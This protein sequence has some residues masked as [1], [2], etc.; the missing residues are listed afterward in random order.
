[1]LI[2]IPPNTDRTVTVLSWIFFNLIIASSF[3]DNWL[4]VASKNST[5]LYAD[6]LYVNIEF[7]EFPNVL[8]LI[9]KS[10]EYSINIKF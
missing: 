2:A 3:V 10:L 9:C 6:S 8:R 4:E 5:V 7:A 1:M